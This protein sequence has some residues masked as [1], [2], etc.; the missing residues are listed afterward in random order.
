[1]LAAAVLLVFGGMA[2]VESHREAFRQRAQAS[3]AA[4]YAQHR[5]VNPYQTPT[6]L[7]ERQAHVAEAGWQQYNNDLHLRDVRFAMTNT[8]AKL[9]GIKRATNDME[10]SLRDATAVHIA[11]DRS[12]LDAD[13]NATHDRMRLPAHPYHI[14]TDGRRHLAS[15]MSGKNRELHF[16]TRDKLKVQVGDNS[17]YTFDTAG[18]KLCIDGV[19]VTEQQW[20]E[21][22]D[23]IEGKIKRLKCNE[24]VVKGALDASTSKS[25]VIHV[26]SAKIEQVPVYHS[27]GLHMGTRI[28]P[29]AQADFQNKKICFSDRS[30]IDAAAMDVV[31][32]R[33]QFTLMH[34]SDD[35][36]QLRDGNPIQLRK[37]GESPK[38]RSYTFPTQ[39]MK[40]GSGAGTTFRFG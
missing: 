16:S 7:G 39:V 10:V 31:D 25:D 38:K 14:Q 29:C 9:P 3:P 4:V 2:C 18:Q 15:G 21:M 6:A 19:C 20:G 40:G 34:R 8:K 24:L 32:G 37:L 23:V 35:T 36:K 12:T 5:G 1:M 28:E 13:G 27:E 17:S 33:T 26:N 30:C 11:S 22:K